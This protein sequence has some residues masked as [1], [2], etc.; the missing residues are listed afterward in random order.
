MSWEVRT[1]RSATSYFNF[2]L[3]RKN[4]ARFWPIWS[5]YGLFWL[6]VL[7]LIILSNGIDWDGGMAGRLPVE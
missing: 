6:A 4:F 7:P 2:T 5:L 3:L 1:M